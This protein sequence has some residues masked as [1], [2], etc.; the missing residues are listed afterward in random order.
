MQ[1][2]DGLTE[3]HL[4]HARGLM[5]S[6]LSKNFLSHRLA[7]AFG[8]DQRLLFEALES[9]CVIRTLSGQSF[10]QTGPWSAVPAGKQTP[11]STP[12]DSASTDPAPQD[13]TYPKS[14]SQESSSQESASPES[15]FTE[16]GFAESGFPESG[17]PESGSPESGSPESGSPE[18]GACGSGG[19]CAHAALRE[20]ADALA[21]QPARKTAQRKKSFAGG[22]I[23]INF[24]GL[25]RVENG[26]EYPE[27]ASYAADEAIGSRYVQN[28]DEY[29]LMSCGHELAHFVVGLMHRRSEIRP[30][31]V[32]FREV[33]RFIR[34]HAVNPLLDEFAQSAAERVS[35]K[36][37]ARLRTKLAALRKMAEDP[38]SNE[39]EAERA[40]RQMQALMEKHGIESIT[41]AE[42]G[43]TR[44]IE[45]QV[46]VLSEGAYKPLQHLFG[47]IGTFCGCEA[48]ITTHRIRARG[49]TG[50]SPSGTRKV[51][52]YFGA[53]ED[54]EMAI[55]LSRILVSALFRE[56]ENYRASEDYAR[57]RAVGVAPRTL[58]FAFRRAFVQ[59]METRLR[60]ARRD[61]E[62]DW[63]SQGASTTALVTDRKAALRKS[64]EARYPRLGTLS[65]SSSG[66]EN[67]A[68]EGA[69]RSAANRVN[70]AR[71]LGVRALPKLKG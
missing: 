63:C 51:V 62:A 70:L 15:G 65:L 24:G 13:S 71:P 32:E 37:N 44:F 21:D 9:L 25:E 31:G 66:G 35:E 40:M 14:G 19:V 59:R 64:F 4:E 49:R 52:K 60:L 8:I 43:A 1:I 38:T 26:G 18:S 47:D 5:Q 42:P 22:V 20:S 17:F 6:L 30:H 27:Y 11:V 23:H 28:E 57:E 54:V 67:A 48:V 3:W 2:R 46:P 41:D 16:S 29:L 61:I 12:S 36:F 34:A 55:Y 68:A 10:H 45:R 39:H 33:Y 69:G 56:T 50:A 7:Q 53:P 58:I